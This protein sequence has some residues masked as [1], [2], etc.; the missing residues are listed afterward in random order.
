[1]PELLMT[2]AGMAQRFLADKLEIHEGNGKA[3][4]LEVKDVKGLGKAMDVILYDGTLKVKDNLIIGGLD[5]PTVTKVKAI[6]NA[7]KMGELR[8]KRTKFDSVPE[9]AA[10]AG[11]RISANDLDTVVSGVPIVSASDSEIEAA[12][13]E[14]QKEI[15]EVTWQT[16]EEG[17]IVKADSLGSLEARE[18]LLKEKNIPIVSASIGN[19]SKKDIASAETNYE[20]DPLNGVILGFNV[21]CDVDSGKIKII[22]NAVIYKI[23][24]DLE[25]WQLEQE[26]KLEEK[27]LDNLVRPC[28]IQ[29][30][31]NYIFRQNN[32]A[33]IG[34]EVLAGT[35]KPGVPLMYEG[36]QI[37]YVKS[38]KSEKDSLSE[39]EKG[40]QAAIALDNVTIGRTIQ[41]DEIMYTNIP[42]EDFRKMK[43]FKK[44]LSKE[45]ISLLKEIAL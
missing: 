37:D 27:A 10:A 19:I 2:V 8:D 4:V 26:R 30:L 31:K 11:V 15:E 13:I 32:P 20:K 12:K 33:V 17:I 21:D 39:L 29:L 40:K 44:A 41:G 28:K 36:R 42:E 35:L 1:M 7:T 16:A 22:T 43:E 45:D 14:V 9:I 38:I 3:I 23:I 24:E 25:K 34:C 6:F 5:N 18:V